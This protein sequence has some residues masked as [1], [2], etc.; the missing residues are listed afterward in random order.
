MVWYIWRCGFDAHPMQSHECPTTCK[1]KPLRSVTISNPL[2]H[3]SLR[4]REFVGPIKPGKI[5]A[6]YN[7]IQC[8]IFHLG[9]TGRVHKIT[10]AQQGALIICAS[11]SDKGPNRPIHSKPDVLTLRAWINN[12]SQCDRS[13]K[14]SGLSGL[15][16]FA[17]PN[18]GQKVPV[19]A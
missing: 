12:R 16:P 19:Q 7:A 15:R 3:E 11:L 13:V 1:S 17:W 6:W 18:Q 10:R 9:P 14:H 8:L 4:A 2:L 5:R